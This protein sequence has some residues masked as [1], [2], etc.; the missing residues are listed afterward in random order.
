[1]KKHSAVVSCPLCWP[2]GWAR[3]PGHRRLGGSQFKSGS[4]YRV[5]GTEQR[6]VGRSMITFDRARTLLTNE[7]GRMKAR[8]VIV[9]TNVPLRMDGQPR[10][11][12]ARARMADPGVAVYFTFK[13]KPMVMAQDAYSHIAANVRSL[14]LAIEALRQLDR[15]GGGTM[16]ERAFAGFTA[17]PPPEGAKPRRPWWEVLRYPTNPAERELLSVKEVQARY[18][19]LAKRLHPDAGGSDEAMTELNLALEDA[20]LELEAGDIEDGEA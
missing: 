4:V 3:T 20:E 16:M 11:D 7:L 15:H 14:G 2:E 12:A 8:G 5:E 9:S 13:G 17:L 19:T 6:Y 10:A 1:M 18:Q